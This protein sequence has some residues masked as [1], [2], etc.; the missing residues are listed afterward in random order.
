MILVGM[1]FWVP[2]CTELLTGTC[3]R[4]TNAGSQS[5]FHANTGI[6]N[7][8]ILVGMQFW[9]PVCTE[10]LTGTCARHTNAGSQSVFHVVVLWIMTL[11]SVVRGSQLIGGE[12]GN[13]SLLH[14]CNHLP[15]YTVS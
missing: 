10:L 1:Q 6:N 12:E 13:K 7:S 14:V 3:A 15:G 4:H 9:V 5:V 11:Y 8:I 2:V